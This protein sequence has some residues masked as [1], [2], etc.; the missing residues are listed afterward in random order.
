MR[1]P[2]DNLCRTLNASFEVLGVPKCVWKHVPISQPEAKLA[3]LREKEFKSLQTV[4]NL[5]VASIFIVLLPKDSDAVYRSFFEENLLDINLKG[6]TFDG[7]KS[8]KSGNIKIRLLF[9]VL[10]ATSRAE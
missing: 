8:T 7:I 10:S 2:E 3:D 1:E 4:V 9:C 5:F 6:A